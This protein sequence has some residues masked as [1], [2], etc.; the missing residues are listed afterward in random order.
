MEKH[1]FI[2]YA[3]KEL[4]KAEEICDFLEHS[5]ISCWIAPRNI[6]PG[7]EYGEEI[8][9]GIE[10]SIAFILVYSEAANASQH[11][12]REVE[13]AVAKKIPLIAYK[14]EDAPLSKSM[15]Y[16]LLSNQWLDATVKGNHTDELYHSI[17]QIMNGNDAKVV[18]EAEL[19]N[20]KTNH[21]SKKVISTICAAAGVIIVVIFVF[22][23][24]NSNKDPNDD[25][26]AVTTPTVA[27]IKEVTS[28]VTPT[29]L[30]T[31]ITTVENPDSATPTVEPSS[32]LHS[33]NP[34]VQENT[35]NDTQNEPT[36]TNIVQPTDNTDNLEQV[37]NPAEQAQD[38]PSFNF[39]VGQYLKF[40]TYKP[41]AYSSTNNDSAITW[42]I[43]NVDT[44]K[45]QAVLISEK[46]L[47]MKPFD[48]A[49]SGKF[50]KDLSGNS[51]DR[52]IKETYSQSQIV[53]FRGNSDWETSN[54]RTWLNSNSARVTYKDQAPV[55][56][57]TDEEANYYDKQSGFLYDFTKEEISLLCDV[58]NT[59]TL[60]AINADGSDKPVYKFAPG[61]ISAD[62]NL[63]K[64]ASK[65]T[66]DKVYLLSVDEVKK[67]L[68]NNNLLI[69]ASPTQSAID[70]DRSSFYKVAL[71]YNTT[72]CNWALRTP[73]GADST[74]VLAVGFGASSKQDIITYYASASGFGI[75]PAVTIS[76][77]QLTVD[78]EGTADNPYTIK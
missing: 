38:E 61:L 4:K 74:S 20:N 1:V 16:F 22:I 6:L 50:N 31:E 59:T 27:I 35:S 33:E 13:R 43:V 34:Q 36:E 78:G 46:V 77:E 29:Q 41:Q 54:I 28:T 25:I 17:Q 63:S 51:Y 75:R 32:D 44:E 57:G 2:S 48:C 62:Y 52:S 69:F 39:E 71:S 7:S 53:E 21:L 12:L 76:L 8:I 9:K 30:L 14:I 70:S 47:D 49:E 73:D 55:S 45:K 72:Y 19:H 56:T 11:V 10:N 40:G 5:G 37:V 26:P 66:T 15:E 58:V 64:Y 3:S 23:L 18:V 65:K 67:Y 24:Q 68:Y 60:N 42:I